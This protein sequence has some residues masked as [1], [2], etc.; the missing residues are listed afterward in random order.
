MV[1]TK[2]RV[3]I[4]HLK[5]GYMTKAL[6]FLFYIILIDILKLKQGNIC[7]KENTVLNKT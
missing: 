3:G 1:A 4:E 5:Y 7:V 2:P 6:N